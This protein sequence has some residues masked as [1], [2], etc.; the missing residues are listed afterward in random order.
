VSKLV[1]A[2]TPPKSLFGVMKGRVMIQDDI[3]SPLDVD[4]QENRDRRR[5]R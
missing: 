5:R 1:Q 4:W 2:R 3:V